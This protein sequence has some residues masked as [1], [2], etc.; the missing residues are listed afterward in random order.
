MISSVGPEMNMKWMMP[1]L[2]IFAISCTTQ[3]DK[4]EFESVTIVPH[5]W[6]YTVVGTNGHLRIQSGT[7]MVETNVGETFRLDGVVCQLSQIDFSRAK[8]RITHL[9]KNETLVIHMG[10]QVKRVQQG[11]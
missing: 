7:K 2:L 1:A 10:P 8:V 6:Q 9:D 5:Q 3:Q 4:P 11:N